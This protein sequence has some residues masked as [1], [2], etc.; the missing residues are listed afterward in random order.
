MTTASPSAGHPEPQLMLATNC[1]E[2]SATSKVVLQDPAYLRVHALRPY[3][4]PQHSIAQ[5][6]CP[7]PHGAGV[8][9]IKAAPTVLVVDMLREAILLEQLMRRMLKLGQGLWGAAIA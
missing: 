1:G 9:T 7:T 4:A 8:P 3:P 2:T 5:T 6:P